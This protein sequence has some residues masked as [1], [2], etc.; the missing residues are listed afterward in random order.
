M[1]FTVPPRIVRRVTLRYGDKMFFASITITSYANVLPQSTLGVLWPYP[2][3]FLFDHP[4]WDPGHR[5]G[6]PTLGTVAC[7][8]VRSRAPPGRD[9]YQNRELV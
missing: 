6:T 9:L 5:G 3:R 2:L 4:D 8:R 1:Y 7:R